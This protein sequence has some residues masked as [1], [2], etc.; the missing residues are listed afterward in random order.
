[1][2]I[3]VLFRLRMRSM[4]WQNPAMV[5][6]Q[7]EFAIGLLSFHESGQHREINAMERTR[8]DFSDRFALGMLLQI[9]CIEKHAA[10]KAM[11]R[12]GFIAMYSLPC[13]H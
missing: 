3:W 12:G 5:R 13:I 11:I 9:G 2:T 1:M 8:L 6:I 4:R 7:S 10:E